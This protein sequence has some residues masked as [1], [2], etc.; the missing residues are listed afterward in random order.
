LYCYVQTIIPRA[1]I[2]NISGNTRKKSYT[3]IARQIGCSISTVSREVKRNSNRHGRYIFRVAV[4]LTQ[5]R[6]ERSLANRRTPLHVLKQAVNLL[7][8]EDWSPKQISGYLKKQGVFISHERIYREI[9]NDETGE[10]RK[11]CRHKLKYRHHGHLKRKTAG[12]T[13]IPNRVLYMIDL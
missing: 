10:Y 12:K 5:I 9:R 1:K 11:H 7:L 3:A 6:R 2:R 8:T 4:E 13:L